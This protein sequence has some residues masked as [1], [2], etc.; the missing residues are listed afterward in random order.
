MRCFA[1][2]CENCMQTN[3]ITFHREP[4]PAL[5]E[6]FIH[7]CPHCKRKCMHRRIMTKKALA[8]QRKQE[9]EAALKKSIVEECAKHGF[10]CRFLYESVVVTTPLADWQ[11]DYHKDKKTLYHE[12]TV[13]INFS[14]G[15]YAKAH[16]QFRDR[17][18][19]NLEIISYV[20]RHDKNK[21]RYKD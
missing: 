11:F 15:D 1:C 10:T 8:E 12:S 6:S 7:Y 13:K 9:Q 2:V 3:Q 19:S 21:E 18:I 5:N 14:T 17:K 16:I 4:Y 20:A